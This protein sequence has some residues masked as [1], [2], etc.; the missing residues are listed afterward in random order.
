MRK[1]NST[2]HL[3]HIQIPLLISIVDT[4]EKDASN[5]DRKFDKRKVHTYSIN[6]TSTLF[7]CSIRAMYKRVNNTQNKRLV[8][9]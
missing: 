7:Y 5:I 3:N 8:L 1:K 2:G 9:K 4:P 6:S